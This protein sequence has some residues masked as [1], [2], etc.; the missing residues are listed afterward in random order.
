M[1]VEF[2]EKSKVLLVRLSGEID[3]HFASEVREKIDRAIESYEKKSLALDFTGVTFMDS[4]GIGVVMGRYNKI[5]DLG[6]IV[7]VLGCNSYIDRILEM[8]G[9]Y[10]IVKKRDTLEEIM[11]EVL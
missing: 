4:S 7:F 3:H 10:T 5:K 1:K 6:G 11:K 9:I 2:E 8:A